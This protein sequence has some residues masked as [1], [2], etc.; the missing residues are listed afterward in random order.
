[1]LEFHSAVILAGGKSTRMGFDKQ[2]LKDQDR[3]LVEHLMAVLKTR[4]EDIMVS[5]LTPELYDPATVRVIKDIYENVGPLGGIHSAL[6]S[7]K[8]DA[9]FVT[10]CDMPHVDVSYIDFMMGQMAKGS[11]DACVTQRGDHLEV[12]HAFYCRSALPALEVKLA[13]GRYSVQRFVRSLNALI[14]PE[15]QARTILPDWR[16]FTNLNTPEEYA[17]FQR[18]R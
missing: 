16:V 8:S 4:F 6:R 10:A 11:Y 15:E 17:E 1:M 12:F 18:R 3:F 14:I 5:S 13:E 9:V 2:L 7:A